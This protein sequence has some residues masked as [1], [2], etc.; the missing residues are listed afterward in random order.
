VKVVGYKKNLGKGH[1]VRYGIAKSSGDIIGFMDA[2]FDL[3]PEG[4]MMLLSTN[5]CF[6]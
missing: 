4:L 5:N 1:A 6:F 3:D 2:G